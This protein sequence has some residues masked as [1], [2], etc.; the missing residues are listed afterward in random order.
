MY[1]SKIVTNNTNG[2]TFLMTK[3]F[4][5]KDLIL[6]QHKIKELYLRFRDFFQVVYFLFQSNLPFEI[7]VVSLGSSLP[8]S[9]T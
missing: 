4:L 1:Q 9:T 6:F 7:E 8:F 5:K 2:I 3:S